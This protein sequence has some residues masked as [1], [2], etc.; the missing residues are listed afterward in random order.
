[1][2]MRDKKSTKPVRGEP[3]VKVVDLYCGIGA[4]THGLMLEGLEVVAGV[5]NDGSCKYGFEKNNRAKFIHRDISRFTAKE[6]R[7]LFRGATVRVLV[8]CA[9]CQPYSSLNRRKLPTKEARRRWYP[10][11]RFMTLIE[12]VKPEIVSMENVPDLS[13]AR[14]YPVF[15]EF[16][17][18]LKALDYAVS[19]KRVDASRFG[20]PQ[21]RTRLV[22]LASRLGGDISLIPETHGAEDIVT[23]REAIGALPRLKDGGIDPSDPMHRASKLN[24]INR[25]RI[26]ATP[27]NGGSATSWPRHLIPKCYR[28]KSG[29]SYMVSVYGRLRW[30]TPASTITTQFMT[31]GTGRFG[32]PS[33]NRAISLRE[34]AK[35]QTFPDYY[36]FAPKNEVTIKHTARHIGNAVPVLLGR[37]I[38]KSIKRHIR[39][40]SK[41]RRK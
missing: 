17:E 32:H 28:R 12:R 7:R 25:K 14:K 15:Q 13:D 33:Q 37:A 23:L 36:Q 10:M 11:Y 34:A 31:L 39:R 18:T 21:K 41:S 8:G 40:Y 27:R 2:I 3:I 5:D 29:K 19:F 38:G 30:G 16:V 24:E 22:L 26:A 6:L 9:P 4:L 20:V 35:L 1:M